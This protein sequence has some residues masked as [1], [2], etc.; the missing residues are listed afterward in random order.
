M[1]GRTADR[2]R[3]QVEPLAALAALFAVGVGL[4]TYAVVLTDASPHPER[5]VAAPTLA[6]VHDAVSEQG[7]VQPAR[8]D[9]A[10]EYRPTG[11][12]LAVTVAT[13]E[14]QWTAGPSPPATGDR[15]ERRVSVRL[16]PGRV[17]VGWLRVV[18][19]R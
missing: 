15:A 9:R 16:G 7:V 1:A 19:W 3:G 14:R 6:A 8:L 12:R 13:D 4:S 18:V 5:D 10:L 11:R 2:C 17:R